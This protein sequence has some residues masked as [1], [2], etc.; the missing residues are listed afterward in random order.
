MLDLMAHY[1][2]HVTGDKLLYTPYISRGFYFREFRESGAIRE[3]I[4]TRK[5]L[6]PIP[7]HE[8]D[9]CTQYIALLDREFNHSRKC[10]KVPIREKLDSRNIWHIQYCLN[11]CFCIDITIQETYV[12]CLASAPMTNAI[13]FLSLSLIHYPY[14]TV[15][16]TTNLNPILDFFVIW[17]PP[18]RANVRLPNL[19]EGEKFEICKK[20]W[21]ASDGILANIL[22][23]R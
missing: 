20:Q 21:K 13:L 23:R 1:S 6:P 7:T 22:H 15:N 8:C 19:S 10:L 4:N 17:V 11:L 12:D 9:L 5:Y 16:Q 14:P 2:N 18:T 3:F